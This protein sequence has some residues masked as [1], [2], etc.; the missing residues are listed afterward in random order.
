MLTISEFNK[1]YPNDNACLEELKDL[2]YKGCSCGRSAL[3]RLKGRRAYSCACGKHFYPCKDTIFANSPTS[4]VLWFYAIYLMSVTKSGISAAQ[5]TRMLGVNYDTAWRMM[6]K[7]RGIMGDDSPLTGPV[8]V[9]ETYFRAKPWRSARPLAYNGRAQTVFGVVERGG[10]ARTV[11]LPTNSLYFLKKS[12]NKYV[13]KGEV[14]YSDGLWA[15][16][17]IGKDYEH[18]SV[19]HSRGEY[20]R[21]HVYTNNIEN[22]WSHIKRGIYGVYRCVSPEHLQ[23]YLD[24]YTFRYS[25]RNGDIFSELMRRV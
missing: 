24:E 13:P 16:R 11:V 14:L 23:N 6:M 18:Y 21:D 25:Y 3:Y 4:L 12:V 20:V 9:D 1:R 15:Y 8:E 7:I 17:T 10:R 22:V 5:M 19:N 2:T